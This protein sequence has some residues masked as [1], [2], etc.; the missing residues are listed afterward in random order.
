LLAKREELEEEKK[1][2]EL[3]SYSVSVK[4]DPEF[5]PKIIGRR[6]TIIS[7]IRDKYH[8]TIQLPQRGEGNDAE[9]DDVITI[10]GFQDEANAARE[11]ILSIVNEF[12]DQVKE[13][14]EIDHRVHSRII[15]SRGKNIREI[16]KDY[17][18]EIRFPRDNTGNPNLVVI[19]GSNGDKVFD[20]RD[21]LLNLEEEYL[22]DVKENEFMQQYVRDPKQDKDK[23]S[24][25]KK[26]N[27][28]VVT[29][30]PWEQAPDTQSNEEF[31]SMMGNGV[32]NSRPISSAW[33]ARKHY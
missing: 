25:E 22:Q 2:K 28:F 31:P 13:S 19:S 18:V 9:F 7:G 21:H 8:V 5:H 26:N 27:G 1:T 3:K 16:M 20:A 11:E 10:T 14:V 4:V 23:A 33:G 17:D 24:K 6:G 12:I 29:G 32:S 30:A 15:G